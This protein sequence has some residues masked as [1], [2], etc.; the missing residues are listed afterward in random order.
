MKK[1]LVLLFAAAL[2]GCGNDTTTQSET[3]GQDRDKL[4]LEQKFAIVNA[5]HDLKADDPSIARS[6][7]LLQR[8]NAEFDDTAEEIADMAVHTSNILK[9]EGVEVTA[10]E[11]LEAAALSKVDNARMKFSEAA[12]MYATLR[13]GGQPHAEAMLGMKGMLTAL[14]QAH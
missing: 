10:M 14:T 5:G 9:E 1:L 12:A 6:Q 8:A 3:I 4:T 2:I 7:E 11:V 13:K